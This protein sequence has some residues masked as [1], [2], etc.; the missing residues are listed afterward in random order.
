M[1][2]RLRTA[3]VQGNEWK[4]LFRACDKACQT[5]VTETHWC[6]FA[7]LCSVITRA[8]YEADGASASVASLWIKNKPYPPSVISVVNQTPMVDVEVWQDGFE[9]SLG[10]L[11]DWTWADSHCWMKIAALHSGCCSAQP[12][13]PRKIAALFLLRIFC[14]KPRLLPDLA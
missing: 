5:V 14:W 6:I 4:R 10:M 12:R 7:I 9:K 3:G 8:R 13:S 2:G 11:W 1:R